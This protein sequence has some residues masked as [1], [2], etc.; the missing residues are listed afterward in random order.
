MELSSK[1]GYYEVTW[2]DDQK[3]DLVLVLPG[4]AYKYASDREDKWL[5]VTFSDQI[6]SSSLLLS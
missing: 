1:K 5:Q 4:G 6:S 3:R 2:F